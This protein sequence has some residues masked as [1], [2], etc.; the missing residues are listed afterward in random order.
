MIFFPTAARD[1][2]SETPVLDHMFTFTASE[3]D[4]SWCLLPLGGRSHLPIEIKISEDWPK[5]TPKVRSHHQR[6]FVR[7]CVFL[8]MPTY[9]Q[10]RIASE[11]LQSARK[12]DV[13]FF[14][15]HPFTGIG[16][17]KPNVLGG[18]YRAQKGQGGARAGTQQPR[19]VN[20]VY[21]RGPQEA[22]ADLP[23]SSSAKILLLLILMT[24]F[25]GY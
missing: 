19:R 22:Q 17:F 18:K 12:P 9:N 1:N 13:H 24:V 25:S 2:D 8:H 7:F 6:D 21:T 14:M 3:Y 4:T 11:I 15:I 16:G 5:K 23:E 20:L 10:I